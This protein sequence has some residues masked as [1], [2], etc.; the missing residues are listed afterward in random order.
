MN[1]VITLSQ[2]LPNIKLYQINNT[3]VVNQKI[4][5]TYSSKGRERI[6]MLSKVNVLS[7]R[8]GLI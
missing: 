1:M 8:S 2:S 3:N 4:K 6:H 5:K 7:K